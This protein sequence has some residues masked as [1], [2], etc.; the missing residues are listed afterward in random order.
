MRSTSPALLAALLLTTTAARAEPS[1]PPHALHV[2]WTRDGVIVG[3]GA[4][5][6]LGSEL[7]LKTQ[8][9]PST[10]R[11]CERAADGT[12][13]V[14]PVDQWGRGMADPSA[15][16][17]A[18]AS[19]WSD[20][21][22]AVTAPVSVLGPW[23]LGSSSGAPAAYLA[24]DALIITQ[25]LVFSA[26]LNQG[27][28]FAVGR[29]RPFVHVL[30]EEQKLLT[31]HP[32]DNNLSFYS[33]HASSTFALAVAAGTVAELRGYPN[34]GWVWGVGLPLAA[35]TALLRMAADKHYVSDV[36]VGA[37]VGSAFGVAVPLLLHGRQAP[38]GSSAAT[39]RVSPG[40]GVGGLMISGQ[41]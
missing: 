17:R 38:A 27:V 28:K 4:V 24:E 35:S 36:V 6:W 8:L 18:R 16:G 20:V 23:L 26:V 5:L 3:A 7:V 37:L 14:N 39:L 29:E 19:R 9:A 25:A 21:T 11:V 10:C 32:E 15:E 34:R 41:F 31:N 13:L 1:A 22:L 40:P 2:D 30:P 12:S 33:G